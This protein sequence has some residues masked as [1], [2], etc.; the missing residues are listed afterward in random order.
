[1]CCSSSN[2]DEDEFT[3][4]TLSSSVFLHLLVPAAAWIK[5]RVWSAAL[6]ICASLCASVSATMRTGVQA[7]V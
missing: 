7:C 1:M 5:T 3:A 2:F 4:P 6:R